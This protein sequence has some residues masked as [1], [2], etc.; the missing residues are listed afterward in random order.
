MIS[1]GRTVNSE[2]FVVIFQRMLMRKLSF[3]LLTILFLLSCRQPP[4]LLILLDP[5]T[6]EQLRT[7]GVGEAQLKQGLRGSFR[8]A[9]LVLNPAEQ[10]EQAIDQAVRDRRPGWVYLS[11]LFPIDVQALASRFSAVTFVQEGADSGQAKNLIRLAF[12]R[13]EGF[14]RAG[15]AVG[16]L[17]SVLSSPEMRSRFGDLAKEHQPLKAGIVAALPLKVAQEEIAAFR[18]A[19]ETVA[20]SSA[21]V[22]R[23]IGS[24]TDTVKARRILEKMREEG[25]GIFVL[26]T[27]TLTGFC[28]DF[29]RSQ[30]GWAVLEESAGSDAYEDR[31]ALAL[32]EDFVGA[33]KNLSRQPAGAVAEGPVELRWGKAFLSLPAEA[34]AKVQADE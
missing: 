11:Q 28:L 26:K 19:F 25:V 2:L 30:G 20:G 1:A 34:R 17:V 23:E 14:R 6:W 27:Y 5:Y 32:Q 8:P 4:S 29:L 9:V 15:S 24:L 12:R 33:L 13:Q 7:Q 31:V 21:L 22:Y 18:S 16:K 10:A 3:I